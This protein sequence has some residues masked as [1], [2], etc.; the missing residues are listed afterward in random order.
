MVDFMNS[1]LDDAPL[2][3]DVVDREMQALQKIQ[4]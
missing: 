4:L 3:K 2:P 1:G